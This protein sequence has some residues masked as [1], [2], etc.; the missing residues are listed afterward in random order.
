MTV[1]LKNRK[2]SLQISNSFSSSQK[3]HMDAPQGSIDDPFYLIYLLLTFC[4]LYETYLIK[5]GDNNN[6]CSVGS[7]TVL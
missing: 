4:F 5:H 3:V 2:K 1:T 7:L 6:L